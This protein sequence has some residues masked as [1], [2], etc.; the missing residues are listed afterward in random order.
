MTKPTEEQVKT[1]EENAEKMGMHG[2]RYDDMEEKM[3]MSP[4]FGATSF[5][6][7]DAAEQ[8]Q[9]VAD[10]IRK[11]TGQFSMMVDNIVN[12]PDIENK[13]NAITDLASEF[14]TVAATPPPGGNKE[15]WQPLTDAVV[16]AIAPM[17]EK[18][19]IKDPPPEGS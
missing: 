10:T 17:L 12:N 3:P 5:A 9:D 6:E 15:R 16:K 8:A 18:V 7:L 19:G 4:A 14:G 13:V 1:E 2:R 11:R